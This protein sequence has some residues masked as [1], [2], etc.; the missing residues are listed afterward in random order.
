MEVQL[1]C[2]VEVRLFIRLRNAFLD[3]WF[4]RKA[5]VLAQRATSGGKAAKCQHNKIKKEPVNTHLQRYIVKSYE[6]F[7]KL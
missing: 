4:G 3:G 5:E 7:T 6:K 2:A 1:M